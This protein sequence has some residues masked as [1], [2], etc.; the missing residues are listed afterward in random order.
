[1]DWITGVQKVI[2]YV[3]DHIIDSIDYDEAAKQAYSS[4]FHFQRVF[5]ILCGFTLGEY[6]RSRRLSLAGSELA[7]SDAKVID[8]AVKYGYDSPESFGRAF[9]RFHGIS[10]SQAR[11]CGAAL[12]SFSRLSVK[13]ILDGGNMMDYRIEK[14]GPFKIIVKKKRVS[15]KEEMTTAEISEFWRQCGTDGTIPALCKYIPKDNI[16]DKSIVGACFGKDAADE[17]FPYAVGAVYNGMPVTDEGF[18]VEEIPAHTYA[19]FKCVGKM[20]EAFQKLYHQIYSEFF[21][22][23]EYQPCGGTDFEAY[24]S[25]DVTSPDYTCELWISVEK[26]K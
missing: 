25:D 1:M 12:K 8:I 11:S 3:E 21:P 16:F 24:P 7:S 13:L 15:C 26:K 18:T 14:K 22:Q 10:P 20:P 17:N 4:S 23:N 6:I 9:T 5:S 19:V 2:D